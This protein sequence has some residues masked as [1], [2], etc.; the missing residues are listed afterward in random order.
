MDVSNMN[1][2]GALWKIVRRVYDIEDDDRR[3]RVSCSLD[4][5]P[6]A[7][8]F[9]LLRR[10][11]PMRREFRFTRLALTKASPELQKSVRALGF[12]LD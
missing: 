5:A 1:V 7:R 2:E 9:D 3:M 11:Y 10:D 8:N 6:R 4:A 12:Q